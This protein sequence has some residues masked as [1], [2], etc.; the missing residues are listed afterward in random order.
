MRAHRAKHRHEYITGGIVHAHQIAFS[1]L[2][3]GFPPNF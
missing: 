3:E 2:P 1:A